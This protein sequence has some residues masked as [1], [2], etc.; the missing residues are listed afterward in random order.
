MYE[1]KCVKKAWS[2][3]P[4]GTASG[5]LI[6]DGAPVGT[7]SLSVSTKNPTGIPA[8][9]VAG[10]RTNLPDDAEVLV[11]T[12]DLR[13]VMQGTGVKSED[14][15][16]HAALVSAL[17]QDIHSADRAVLSVKK[18]PTQVHTVRCGDK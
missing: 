12:H 2:W 18:Q 8:S 14:M 6:P 15:S 1:G 4:V 9:E 7:I 5:P 3:R 17:K 10:L 16:R 11:S 13:V